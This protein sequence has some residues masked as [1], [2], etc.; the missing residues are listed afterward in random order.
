MNLWLAF[1]SGVFVGWGVMAIWRAFEVTALEDE[2]TL[3]KLTPRTR[4]EQ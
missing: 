1:G 4:G 3:L 2:I